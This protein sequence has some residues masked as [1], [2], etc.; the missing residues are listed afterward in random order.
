MQDFLT[1]TEDAGRLVDVIKE[2]RT[3][4]KD[5][6]NIIKKWKSSKSDTITLEPN[7]G[8]PA[9]KIFKSKEEILKIDEEAKSLLET[10]RKENRGL[11]EEET[12]RLTDLQT[13]KQPFTKEILAAEHKWKV[14][15]D[16]L[17]EQYTKWKNTN[18][19]YNRVVKNLQID[20]PVQRPRSG[21]K[22]GPAVQI[23][24]TPNTVSYT[25]LTLPT[26]CSV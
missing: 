23:P 10:A 8:S 18:S 7:V 5:A 25:H 11:S 1:K 9:K 6:P 17:V 26:I 21:P 15:K 3:N 12:I 22:D 20:D 16:N 4:P 13:Q 24:P 14:A 2:I 19:Y